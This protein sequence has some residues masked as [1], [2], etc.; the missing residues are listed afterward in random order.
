MSRRVVCWFSCGA[1]S[2]VATKIALDV[3]E[4]VIIAYTDT[5][6]E[7]PDHKRFLAE[8][9]EWFGQKIIQ[10]QSDRYTS[11]WQVWRERRFLVGPTGALCTAE[12]KKKVRFK[13]ERPDDIQVFGYTADK[14]DAKRAERFRTQNPGVDLRTPLI[15][16]GLTKTA[17]RRLLVAAGI[18]PSVMYELGFNNSNCVPCVKG[19]I[20]YWNHIRRV[21]PDD[22]A[23]MSVLERE[24]GHS[25]L[26][27]K[28]GPIW[29][30]E[31]HPERGRHDPPEQIDC[32]LLC[33]LD[34]EPESPSVRAALRG[35]S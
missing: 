35:E 19:G 34:D 11:T 6:S 32:G 8:C 17:C 22:F 31:L 33:D 24:I 3:N 29:L 23:Q 4:D 30:D 9:E 20:G 14:K 15:T 16:A 28:D 1:A 2:A 18:E 26:S 12:L 21:F 5:G 13:F 27:D 7:H 10:L 25:V